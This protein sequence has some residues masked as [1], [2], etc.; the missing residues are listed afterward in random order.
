MT[1][2]I[3]PESVE[4]HA[5]ATV[6]LAAPTT[7]QLNAL[8][9]VTPFIT[10]GG[11]DFPTSGK[12]VAADDLSSKFDSVIAGTRGGDQISLTLH[13]DSTLVGDTIFT[14]LAPGFVGYIAVAS[15]PLGTYGT[16]AIGDEV[17]VYPIEV[18]TRNP[19]NLAARGA[20]QQFTVE[21]AVTGEPN[22]DFTIIA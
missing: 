4:I 16:W 10:D 20:T 2:F 12:T 9:D 19:S 17:D 7:T 6:T 22:I 18:I 8:T 1:R 3:G 14:L 11:A 5:G 21:A 13:K 15:R